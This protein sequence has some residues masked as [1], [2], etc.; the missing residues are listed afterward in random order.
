MEKTFYAGSLKPLVND[1]K[2]GISRREIYI[3]R[4]KKVSKVDYQSII[5]GIKHILSEIGSNLKIKDFGNFNLGR[6]EFSSPDWY[7]N[8]SLTEENHGFGKQVNAIT[9][10]QLLRTEP[11]QKENPHFDF[12]IID[13]DLT[14]GLDNN[15]IF[16]YGPYPNSM[17][18]TKRFKHNSLRKDS[19]AM[20]A[21]HEFCHNIGLVYRDFNIGS[22]EY[23]AGHC[24]GEKGPCLMEQV[25]VKGTR[26]VDKQAAIIANKN[27]WL[28]Y[29][30][31]I[32]ISYRREYLKNKRIFW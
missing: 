15:W 25:N 14:W 6:G 17:I 10:D 5:K 1:Y 7:Q 16:G 11:F 22:G 26:D 28:C 20:M 8:N 12:M 2:R 31:T 29:S 23:K 9:L 21:A 18:S 24:N 30:C 4:T 3:S 13:K 19:L 27:G 32:E